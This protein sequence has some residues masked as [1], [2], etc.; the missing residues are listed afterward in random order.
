MK[1]HK[2]NTGKNKPY[3]TS[4]LRV[5]E[6]A[7]IGLSENLTHLPRVIFA[8]ISRREKILI[9]GIAIVLGNFEAYQLLGI[10]ELLWPDVSCWLEIKNTTES[11][12][13]GSYLDLLLTIQRDFNFTLLFM[14]NVAI[15]I[16][17]SQ[18]FCSWVAIF[19]LCPPMASLSCRLC[20]MQGLAPHM[21]VLFWGQ[22]DFPISFSNRGTSRNAPNCHWRSFIVDRWILSNNMKFPSHECFKWHSVAW[23]YTMTTLNLLDSIPNRDHFT[24]I[25]LLKNYERFP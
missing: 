13:S 3:Y 24:E 6:I 14:T 8:K 20:I 5:L 1:S 11:N 23:P 16:S 4:S 15:S 18:T 19:H 25:D 21:D 9:Y 17:I 2:K 22:C 7:K 12:T 10:T